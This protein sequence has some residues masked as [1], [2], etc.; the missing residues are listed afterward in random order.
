MD[1]LDDFTKSYVLLCLRIDQLIPGYV[2]AYMGPPEIKEE[3]ISEGKQDLTSLHREAGRLLAQVHELGCGENRRNFLEKQLTSIHTTLRELKGEN[4]P[5]EK[6]LSL[7]YDISPQC[8][9]DDLFEEAMSELDGL[10]PGA[11]SVRDRF[12]KRRKMFELP[13]E[14]AKDL[15]DRV[16]RESQT[17]TKEFIEM[18]FGE[19]VETEL[20]Q[21]K[22]WDGFNT[23]LDNY[24]SKIQ[25]NVPLEGFRLIPLMCHEAYAGHHTERTMKE[26]LLYKGQG[27]GEHAVFIMRSPENLVANGIGNNAADVLFS[28]VELQEWLANNIYSEIG[29]GEVDVLTEVKIAGV[30][31]KLSGV[32]TKAAR[33]LHEEGLPIAKVRDY[34]ERYLLINEKQSER[35]LN[36]I[37]DPFSH[38]NIHV[39]H[40]GEQLVRRYLQKGDHKELLRRL[41]SQQVYP[42]LIEEWSK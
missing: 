9:D 30:L 1:L 5:Y 35:V 33:M 32:R 8:V 12:M 22:I 31:K 6:K 7:Y 29:I 40:Y 10:L 37:R 17:R 19:R 23:Y 24:R 36:R 42:S 18:P 15:V 38:M 2:D 28:E 25:I 26:H 14:R 27:F 20:V 13:L 4:I 21:G 39:Y 34:L 16:L 11:G 41:I 3:V